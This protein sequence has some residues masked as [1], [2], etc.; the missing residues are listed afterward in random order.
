MRLLFAAAAVGMLLEQ[1]PWNMA[2][3]ISLCVSLMAALFLGLNAWTGYISK[4]RWLN[5]LTQVLIVIWVCLLLMQF[6]SSLM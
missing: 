4:F 3:P 2:K 6:A 1:W 5:R